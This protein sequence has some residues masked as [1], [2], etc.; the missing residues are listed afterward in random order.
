MKTSVSTRSLTDNLS[1][2]LEGPSGARRRLAEFILRNPVRAAAGSIE[3]LARAAGSSPAT[4]SRF[5]RE[6]GHDGFA[7]LRAAIAEGVQQRMD[8]V[9]KLKERLE[10]DGSGHGAGPADMIEAMRRQLGLIDAEAVGAQAARIAGRINAAR[11]VHVMG[12]GLSAHV[13]AMLALGLQP[14]HANASAVVEYGGTEVAAGRLMGV[15]PEDLLIAITVPRY[16][17]DVV[18]L[19]RYARDKG[20]GLVAITDGPASPLAPMAHE[21]VFAPADHPVLSS[22]LTAT[23]AVA[24]AIAAAVML[25]NR[26]NVAKADRLTEAI[27]AYLYRG[28]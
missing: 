25:S 5:A 22:S 1:L 15:G 12:F 17:S 18:A 10:G 24:E 13:A 14:F 3:E 6:L 11:S 21:A 2:A 26:D 27:A 4:V 23:L 9:A 7:S 8:P 16:A 19:S 28:G 20:A